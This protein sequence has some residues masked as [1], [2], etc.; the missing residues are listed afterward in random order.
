VCEGM[1]TIIDSLTSGSPSY[2]HMD[3][4]DPSIGAPSRFG[5]TF[6]G[7]GNVVEALFKVYRAGASSTGQVTAKIY[8]VNTTANNLPDSLL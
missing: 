4:S 5:Q 2:I 8:T 7:G 6:N 3:T 1:S